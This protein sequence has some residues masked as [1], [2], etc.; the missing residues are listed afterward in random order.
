MDR[1]KK[2][3]SKNIKDKFLIVEELQD[4][5]KYSKNIRDKCLVVKE[6]EDDVK[7]I[8]KMR[9]VIEILMIQQ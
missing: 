2:G 7:H 9:E 3:Y 8:Q 6:L 1:N 5:V 4:D